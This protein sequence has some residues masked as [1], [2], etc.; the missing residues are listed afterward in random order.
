MSDGPHKSLPMRL[1]WKKLAEC[2]DNE[3]FSAEEVRARLPVALEEDWR[4]EIPDTLVGKCREIVSDNQT[5][6]FDNQTTDRLKLL[7]REA[8]GYPIRGLFLDYM[9]WAVE[10]EYSGDVAL[11][12]AACETLSDLATRGARQVEEHYCRKSTSNR[13]V[14]VR[15]RIENG[16]ERADIM[17]ITRRFVGVD[18]SELSPR[19]VKQTSLDDGVQL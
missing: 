5:D 12:K 6:F 7:R 8:A 1:G 2:A 16:I 9:I 4:K 3:A 10:Q 18:K 15:K 14:D 11:I 13:A 19:P 17:I